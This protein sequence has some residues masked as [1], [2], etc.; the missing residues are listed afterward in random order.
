MKKFKLFALAL[1]IGT[2][3]LF[4][5]NV[6]GYNDPDF[7]E[8]YEYE[9]LYNEAYGDADFYKK[10]EQENKVHEGDINYWSK[11]LTT[12]TI[13]DDNQGLEVFETFLNENYK[14]ILN[15]DILKL[16]NTINNEQ[17]SE[18]K[19][20]YTGIKTM[21]VKNKVCSGTVKIAKR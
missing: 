17:I 6:V 19:K 2:G 14:T 7:D 5:E 3:S 9:E 20:L 13:T 16:K 15:D 1:A 12:A 18:S 8:E 4:A 21:V 10:L 11:N